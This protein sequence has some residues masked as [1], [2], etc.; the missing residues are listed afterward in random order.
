MYPADTQ[1]LCWSTVLALIGVGRLAEEVHREPPVKPLRSAR[2]P[3]L[4]EALVQ[5]R[6]QGARSHKG[7]GDGDQG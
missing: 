6:P 2:L 1:T 4:E 5:L 7:M 3:F